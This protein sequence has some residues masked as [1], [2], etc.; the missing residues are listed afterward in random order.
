MPMPETA[1]NQNCGLPPWEDDI[2]L[3]RKPIDVDP[4]P[5]SERMKSLSKR[6]LGLR[7]PALDPAHHSGTRLWINYVCHSF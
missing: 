4:E 7:V 1:L 6:N 3:S 2:R 5:V